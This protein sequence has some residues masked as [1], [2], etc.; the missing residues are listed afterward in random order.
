MGNPT[1]YFRLAANDASTATGL[2]TLQF[3]K[4]GDTNSAYTNIPPLTL[5]VQN[6]KCSL[7]AT[8]TTYAIPMGGM[9]LPIT[10]SAIDCIPIDSINFT[11]T[12]TGT[13]NT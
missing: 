7:A 3:T 1:A 4:T 9:T 5:V 11:M 8:A 12:F 2:Y 6:T 10:I 13:G